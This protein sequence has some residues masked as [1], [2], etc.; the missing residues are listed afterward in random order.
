MVLIPKA[1]YEKWVM[2]ENSVE[3]KNDKEELPHG[4]DKNDI[5]ANGSDDA[6]PPPSEDTKDADGYD[7]DDDAPIAKQLEDN[8][9]HYLVPFTLIERMPSKY[10]LY[11]KRLLSYIKRHGGEKMGWDDDDDALM[12]KGSKIE[13]SDIIELIMH[14][15]KSNRTPPLGIK[16]FMKASD[17]IRVPKSF[18]K[19]YVLK[20][21]GMPK[22]IKNKWLKY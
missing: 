22:S 1:A 19:P 17:E 20:P 21:P 4:S 7:S 14:V 3:M 8:D 10:R 13:G 2:S 18:F 15:F 11:G 12:Y 16:Q 6:S 5:V 9:K